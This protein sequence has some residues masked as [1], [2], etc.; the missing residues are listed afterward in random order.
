MYISEPT[1]S[2]SN[3]DSKNYNTHAFPSVAASKLNSNLTS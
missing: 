1:V 2:S 3:M